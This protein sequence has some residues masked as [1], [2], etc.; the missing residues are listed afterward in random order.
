M[1]I[2]TDSLNKKL[3]DLLKT[4]GLKPVAKDSENETT[5]VPDEAEVIQFQLDT[6]DGTPEVLW[7]TVD[8]SRKLTLYYDDDVMEDAEDSKK[9][10]ALRNHL[11]NWA[12]R[13]QLGFQLKNKDHLASDM[14]QRDYMNKKEKISE[15]YYPMGKTASYSD[16]VPT[17]KIV[18]QHNRSIQEGEQ[19]YRNIAKIFLE[20]QEGERF[21]APTTKPGIARVYARHIAEGGQPHDDR[22]NHIGSLCEEY[23]KMAGF[24]RATRGSQFN[25]SAQRLV[26]E[27][28]NH[29]Q[30]LRESLGKMAGHRGYNN[31]FE[32]W[33][34]PLM[35]DDSDTS[36]IN[37]LFVQETV[38]PRIESVMPILSKLHK[39]IA[40]M[41]EVSELAEW[42]D[43]LTEAPGAETLAHNDSTDEKRLQALDLEEGQ[44]YDD[45]EEDF[46]PVVS[47]ITRRIIRQHPELLKHGPD[48]VMAAIADVADFVGDAEEIGSSDVSGWVRQVAQSLG[49]KLEEALDP[50]KKQRLDDLISRY[51]DATD[52]EDMGDERHEDIIAQIRIEFGDKTADSVENGPSMHFPRPGHSMDHDDLEFRQMRKNTSPNRI[53]KLGKLHKQDSDTLKRDIKSNL[54]VEEGILDTVK[55]VGSKVFD[56]LGGGSEDDLLKKLQKDAGIPVSAQHGKPNMGHSKDK[57]VDE[58]YYKDPDGDEDSVADQADQADTE[59]RGREE[60]LGEGDVTHTPKGL[61][62]KSTDRYGGGEEHTQGERKVAMDLDSLNKQQVKDFDDSIGV[63][64]KKEGPKGIKVDEDSEFAGDY[65]TGEAGQWRNKGPK[66]NKPATIGDLVG[67]SIAEGQEDLDT[68]RRLLGK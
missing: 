6:G 67:E 4:Q 47:A 37:E 15:G 53:T 12:M 48:K 38:D 56:K 7:A 28:I 13:K 19:R 24:V 65:A 59:R 26:N 41:K 44:P 61:I 58:G 21:L 52:P 5:P 22:W 31:Y 34:P 32:S 55:K 10:D 9:W 50:E 46:D 68:I 20:N 64:W 45:E 36:N 11:K 18:L 8:S 57:E 14:A 42:A 40:E 63:R 51:E 62:H 35:E 2:Q 39:N 33:T 66:A 17:V 43:S 23:Q 29:Y 54:D 30:S 27:G 1:P 16:A 49:S 60:E 25:E 3:Y